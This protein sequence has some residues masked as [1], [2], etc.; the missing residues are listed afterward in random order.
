MPDRT[1]V[2]MP[3]VWAVVLVLGDGDGDGWGLG[4]RSVAEGAGM[5][6]VV[7]ELCVVMRNVGLCVVV[8][9]VVG[10]DAAV[11]DEKSRSVPEPVSAVSVG[12]TSRPSKPVLTI[13]SRGPP[14]KVTSLL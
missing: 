7:V 5:T 14:E 8:N 12:T 3:I 9:N 4:L 1:P 2:M 10:T 6:T 11:P 13:P